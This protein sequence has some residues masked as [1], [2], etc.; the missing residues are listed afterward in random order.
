M[1]AN[2]PAVETLTYAA[3]RLAVA[4]VERLGEG[5]GIGPVHQG[6]ELVEGAE[7]QGGRPFR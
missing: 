6:G 3:C 7:R 4:D 2:I 1:I 5:F